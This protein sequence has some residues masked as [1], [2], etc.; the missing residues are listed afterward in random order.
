MRD[1]NDGT[2]LAEFTQGLLNRSFG[3]GIDRARGFVEDE[4]VGVGDNRS[5]QGEALSL[6][7]GE[8][9]A[10]ITDDS[11]I[12]FGQL[13]DEVVRIGSFC[14]GDQALV[15]HRPDGTVGDVVSNASV[16]EI[17]VL[18]DA[19]DCPMVTFEL[20]TRQRLSIEGDCSRLWVVQPKDQVDQGRLAGTD[21]P[22]MAVILPAGITRLTDVSA[23]FG[24][25][26]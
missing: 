21:G 1:D 15:R 9:N 7:A 8:L 12:A 18:A 2:A 4:D 13:H 6:A 20:E 26:R 22:M 23:G 14:R 17:G 19:A 3:L 25:P 24:R 10:P 5:S 16:E 11:V